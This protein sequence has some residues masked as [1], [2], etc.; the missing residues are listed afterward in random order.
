MRGTGAREEQAKGTIDTAN[1]QPLLISAMAEGGVRLA[2][3]ERQVL[4]SQ[5]FQVAVFHLLMST[6]LRDQT[7]KARLVV[8]PIGGK[9]T[10]SAFS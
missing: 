10:V 6:R 5:C 3:Q 4:G 2:G 9:C 1:Q 7:G 8:A